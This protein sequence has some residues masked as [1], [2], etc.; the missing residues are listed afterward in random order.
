MEKLLLLL[1]AAATLS[2]SP[3]AH[4]QPALSERASP[5]CAH[6]CTEVGG[7]YVFMEGESARCEFS[8]GSPIRFT[9]AQD[10][11]TGAPRVEVSCSFC[12]PRR[13]ERAERMS[14]DIARAIANSAP[15][16]IHRGAVE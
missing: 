16:P 6:L 12:S 13:A 2:S 7:K 14:G 5:L 10:A 1:V 11:K 9:A 8:V 15:T 3:A 4:A